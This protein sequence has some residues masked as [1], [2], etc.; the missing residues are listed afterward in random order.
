VSMHLDQVWI[1]LVGPIAG[2]LAGVP[3]CRFIHSSPC[4]GSGDSGERS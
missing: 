3:L 4:G 1:Y 2:A